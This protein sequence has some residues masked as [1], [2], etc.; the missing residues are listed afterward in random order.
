L[1][2]AVVQSSPSTCGAAAQESQD[3][4]EHAGAC[5]TRELVAVATQYGPVRV[6]IGRRGD[7]VLNVAPEFEDCRRI[8]RERGVAVKEVVAAAVAACVLN[9]SHLVR[10]H[11]VKETKDVIEVWK[12]Y[13]A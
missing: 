5:R 9:G 6:K 7:Q 11:D 10:V 2:A 1:F 12:A 13:Q 4:F 8:A 3:F